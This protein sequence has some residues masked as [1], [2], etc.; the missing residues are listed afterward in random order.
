MKTVRRKTSAPLV[1]RGIPVEH[2]SS[3]NAPELSSLLTGDAGL[4]ASGKTTLHLTGD[5][6]LATLRN[7]YAC[8]PMPFEELV[9]YKSRYDCGDV[10][11]RLHPDT[12]A[13]LVAA[14]RAGDAVAAP[15]HPVH[16]VF[17]SPGGV[18]SVLSACSPAFMAAIACGRLVCVAI[19]PTTGKALTE[20]LAGH[21]SSVEVLVSK[22]PTPEGVVDAINA[23]LCSDTASAADTK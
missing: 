1:K 5:M 6:A 9:V 19:G 11:A 3:G 16:A 8:T 18:N 4:L 15:P 21:A 17:F 23:S 12:Q 14:D 22:S 20:K 7:A 10:T 13:M 2:D